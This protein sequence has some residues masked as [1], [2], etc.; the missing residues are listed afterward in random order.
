MQHIIPTIHATAVD[1]NAGSIIIAG[2]FDPAAALIDITV[3]GK[4]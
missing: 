4:S 1:I 2:L 3:D